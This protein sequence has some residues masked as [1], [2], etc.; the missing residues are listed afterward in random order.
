M[1]SGRP[2]SDSS[3]RGEASLDALFAEVRRHILDRQHPITGLLPA[4]TAVTAHGDYTDAWVRDNVYSI[5]APWALGIAC[6]RAGEEARAFELEQ[7]VVRNMR[8]LLQAMMRQ[9]DRVERFKHSLDPIDALHAKY[10]TA[11]GEAVVGDEDWG[12]LQLDATSL[13]L[14]MLIQMTAGGLTIVQSRDEVDFV[15]NLVWYLSRAYVIPDYGIWERGNKINIGVRELNASSLGMVLAALEAADGFDLFGKQGDEATRLQVVPDD[16]VRVAQCLE[17]ILPRE[18]A[19]KE[20]DSA[21]LAVIGFPAFAV[22]RATIA[23]EVRD[24]IEDRLAGGYGYKR[25]LRD[26]HQ[27][28]IEDESK[29][30]YEP[31]EL[32]AFARIE[33]EWPLFF[34]Y[35]LINACFAG[36]RSVAESFNRRLGAIATVEDGQGVIPELY[37]V[38]AESIES[39]RAQPGTSRRLANENRPLVW[40]QSLWVV[41]RLMCAKRIVPEDIDPLGRHRREGGNGPAEVAVALLAE[42][43]TGLARLEEAG[44]APVA[45]RDR[46]EPA[47]VPADVLI[48]RLASLGSN[49]KLGLG[50]RP[51]RRLLGLATAAVIDTDETRCAL[52]PAVFD[53]QTFLLGRDVRLLVHEMR[54]TIAYLARYAR[55]AKRPLF[56]VP[57]ADW[58]LDDPGGETLLAFCRDE[59]AGGSVDGVTVRL[60]SLQRLDALIMRRRLPGRLP[61]W[62]PPEPLPDVEWRAAGDVAAVERQLGDAP[63]L[64][65]LLS[66]YARTHALDER[67]FVLD[68][69]ERAELP[70]QQPFADAEGHD[71]DLEGHRVALFRVAQSLGDWRIM[72]QAAEKAGMVDAFLEVAMMDLVVHQKRV[73]VGR[74][75]TRDAVIESPVA[76][77]EILRRIAAYCGD[78]WRERA[79]TQELVIHLG[80]WLRAEP[81][82]FEDVI[83]LRTGPLL[84][85]LV[86]LHSREAHLGPSQ[87]LDDLAAMPPHEIRLRLREAIT[88]RGHP[89][90]LEALHRRDGGGLSLA[91]A[92][93]EPMGYAA[94]ESTP[95]ETGHVDWY[96]RR[97]VDGAMSRLP[98]VFF[99]GVW[100]LLG[101]VP[102]LVIGNRFDARSLIDSQRY[103]GQYTAGEHNFALAVEHRLNRI[104]APEY[105]QLCIETLATLSEIAAGTP[106]LSIAEP[107]VLDVLTGHA[108]RLAWLAEHPEDADRYDER[109]ADAWQAF[110]RL[111][112]TAV[113]E[114]VTAALEYLLRADA[115]PLQEEGVG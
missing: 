19:S 62:T 55:G 4:S 25:F 95:N 6:R 21:L 20:I 92:P 102:A 29:L 22:G 113:A 97:Q 39:E 103:R 11:T 49:P 73:A 32:E 35:R 110:Y 17:A 115:E 88:W 34:T 56:V 101:H 111:P 2:P 18:S 93:G 91:R 41:G 109:R 16:I 85:I 86:A 76:N 12:H 24:R 42:S 13:F 51:K 82:L 90:R 44:V 60:D 84:Q 37:Y 31:E 78:D 27:T 64:D 68:W 50:G 59:L 98:E 94:V 99:R 108:V 23:A 1:T 53:T 54:T 40:A 57:I 71:R 63:T 46:V 7:A 47:A 69:L 14:L 58:M 43:S 38:P 15:Q 8:G 33:C 45:L 87:A 106:D 36:D 3:D 89:E 70:A 96:H 52:I 77:Q 66:T 5:L 61:S 28:V 30:H 107:L 26:G 9:S 72:R 83:T 104:E 105:R 112:P 10:D 48:E 100:E 74:S 81:G 114:W 79:L 80:A 65:Q 75:Y 67:L